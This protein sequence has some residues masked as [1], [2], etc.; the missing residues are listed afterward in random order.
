MAQLKNTTIS[1]TGFLQLPAGTT[2]QRPTPAAGQIRFNTTNSK[3]EKY[4]ATLSAWIGT[5]ES[6]VIATG[7]NQYDIE[8]EGTIYRVHVFNTTGNS[9]FTVTKSGEVEYL[10]V[11]GGGGGGGDNAGGGGAGGLLTGT[12]TVTPQAYTITVGAGGL[13]AVHN[14]SNGSSGGNSTAFGLTTFGGGVGATGQGT[15]ALA[16]TGGSGGGGAGEGAGGQNTGAA[17][18]AGQGNAGGSSLSPHQGGGGGGGAG[19]VGQ[20]STST[21]G[22]AGGIGLN[23]FITGSSVFYAG[24]GGGGAENSVA[25]SALGGF[26]GGGRGGSSSFA[27]TN[28][29]GSLTGNG[30]NGTLNSG[31]GGG[32]HAFNGSGSAG[33]GDGGSG[34]VIVRYPLRQENSV[35]SVRR[36]ITDRLILDLDFSKSSVYSGI[37]TALSDSRANGLTASL[38][39]GAIPQGLR[40]NGASISVDGVT[41]FILVNP[42]PG[43]GTA[44]NS[45]T[46]ELWVRPTT[47]SGN[48]LAMSSV[49]P[50]GSWNMPPIIATSQRFGGKVWSSSRIQALSTYNLNQ[51]YHL[52]LV[53]NYSTVAAS[54]GQFFY[55]DGVLQGSQTDIEY[56]A[57]GVDNF[58]FLGQQNPGADNAG[59]FGGSYGMLRVYNKAL[60]AQEITDNFNTTRWRFGV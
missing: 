31:G 36:S 40:S 10:I 11:A 29:F 30:E 48:V 22:G 28:R 19:D 3:V 33:G 60:S 34:V 54:R 9:T 37:G 49:N 2:A 8:V 47:T 23:I 15:V 13:G 1:D 46:W 18:T 24:G 35:T 39:N 58:L 7:G 56:N 51:W 53:W 21:A 41:Q 5:P 55:I 25:G 32:G 27:F 16:T 59:M 50:S 4:N 44:T 38:Q 45:I 12:I 6:G 20:N 42:V 17:G 43:I 57:S 52:V 26:G 14:G